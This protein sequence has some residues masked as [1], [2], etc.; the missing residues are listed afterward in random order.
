MIAMPSEAVTQ[1]ADAVVRL[2]EVL[3]RLGP[4]EKATEE[5]PHLKEWL[6]PEEASTILRVHVQTVTAWCREGKLRASKNGGNEINRKGGK[7][8]ISRK[9]IERYLH[10]H[11]VIHGEQKGGA[12]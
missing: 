5:T 1:F 10:R 6:T 2:A 3:E 7:W 8:V 9:E 11:Q 12:E 4:K